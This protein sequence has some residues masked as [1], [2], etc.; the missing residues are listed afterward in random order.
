MS[1]KSLRN[2]QRT[3]LD[4]QAFPLRYQISV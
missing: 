1:G 2:Y 3:I 4:E